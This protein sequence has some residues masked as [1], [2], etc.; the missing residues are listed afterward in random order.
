MKDLF[1]SEF[2]L[3]SDHQKEE[4]K[5]NSTSNSIFSVKINMRKSNSMNS[6]P[7]IDR[8]P[9]LLSLQGMADVLDRNSV[10]RFR[11]DICLKNFSSKHCLKEHGYTHTNDKPYCCSFCRKVFKHASQLSLHK[12]VHNMKKNLIWPKLTDLMKNQQKMSWNS[13]SCP[14]IILP[15]ISVPQ[16]F[17]LPNINILF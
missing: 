8:I 12:K 7:S 17:S 3:A 14:K 15:L 2:L 4:S 16:D 11:C 10:R 9:Q 13:E 1:K 5:S 6:T